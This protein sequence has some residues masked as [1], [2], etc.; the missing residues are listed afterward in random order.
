MGSVSL[1][2]KTEKH[3]CILVGAVLTIVKKIYLFAYR[4]SL[5]NCGLE[6][7]AILAGA[8]LERSVKWLEFILEEN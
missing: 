3:T 1:K 7:N 8:T 5:C 6:M 4:G 2:T